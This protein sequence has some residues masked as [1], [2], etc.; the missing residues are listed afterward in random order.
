MARTKN[1]RNKHTLGPVVPLRADIPASEHAAFKAAAARNQITITGLVRKLVSQYLS[2]VDGA[3]GAIRSE[4][5]YV[6]EQSA[7]DAEND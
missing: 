3:F 6:A 4:A 5:E 1:S 2:Q 7:R